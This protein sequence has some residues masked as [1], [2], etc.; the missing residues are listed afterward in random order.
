M[1][2]K[3]SII[4]ILSLV[5]IGFFCLN[6]FVPYYDDD[7]WYALRYIPHETLSPISNFGDILLSQ[8]H[9]YMGENSRAIIH[10]VLQCL[11]AVLPEWGFDLVN[12]G[13]FILLIWCI[14]I[15]CK[16]ENDPISPLS[17]LIIVTC[18]YGLLPDMDY[19]FY[20]AAGSLNYMWTSVA[21]MAFLIIWR[22]ITKENTPV[23]TYTWLYAIATFCCA[24]THEAF[25]LPVGAG[26][27]IYMLCHHRL[28]RF[29][30]ITIIALAYGLGCLAI[31]IA[32]GLE[33]KSQTIGYESI[34]DYISQLITTL[35]V[36]RVLPIC[37]I[38]ALISILKKT[39]RNNLGRYIRENYLLIIIASVAFI[40]VATL[41]AGAL[42]GRIYYASE[43]FWMLVILTYLHQSIDLLH[44]KY[45]RCA[46]I[47]LGIGLIAWCIYILPQ[48]HKVGRQHHALFSN[49]TSDNDGII[50]LPSSDA[51]ILT[52]NW[53]MDLHKYYYISPESEWRAFVIPLEHLKDTLTIPDTLLMRTPLTLQYVL[54]DKYIQILPEELRPAIEQP[55]QFFTTTHKIAG[56]NPFY[57]VDNG[58]YV[59]TPFDSIAHNEQ[60]QWIYHP[61]SWREPSASLPGTIKRLIAPGTLPPSEPIQFPDTV[62]LPSQERY[63]IILKPPYR[64]V[65]A[66]DRVQ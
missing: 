21:T 16:R 63:L 37:I 22:Q 3:S 28:I 4:I 47:V 23:T 66:I 7:I 13:I 42:H 15:Y 52:Q 43:F 25:A 54:Y 24:F 32:P 62:T 8:Y 49:Y 48:A 39:W 18:I 6:L 19:L 45:S 60:W 50:Y 51:P 59:I 35:R 61:S 34:S 33:N 29:N 55:E 11:L 26:V 14:T 5:A 53:I 41:R 31:L 10:I 46:T 44:C 9:H 40:F 20:W 57:G 64:T 27:L 30:S 36:I 58:R 38:I 12:T 65:K 2:R 1:S 56:D 17:L